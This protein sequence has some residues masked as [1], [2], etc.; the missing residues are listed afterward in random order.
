MGTLSLWIFSPA[1]RFGYTNNF[2]SQMV[3]LVSKLARV[4][5]ATA[6]NFFLLFKK[7]CVIITAKT[8]VTKAL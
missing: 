5:L 4:Q 1:E 2:H 3:S 6:V 8:R 7:A